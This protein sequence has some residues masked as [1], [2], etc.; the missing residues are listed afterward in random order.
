[1]FSV[2]KHNGNTGTN[3]V[4][5]ARKPVVVVRFGMSARHMRGDGMRKSGVLISDTSFCGNKMLKT[6][7]FTN[8]D[9]TS[10]ITC[11][12]IPGCASAH[13]QRRSYRIVREYYA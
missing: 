3:C 9:C 7:V 11:V 2:L 6:F 12:P 8:L 5:K 13:E 4:G 1:M 10:I